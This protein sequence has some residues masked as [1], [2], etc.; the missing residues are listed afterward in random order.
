[1]DRLLEEER[2]QEDAY[3]RVALLKNRIQMLKK[4]R[5]LAK[6]K[7]GKKAADTET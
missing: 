1:M 3:G 4:K 6:A 5:E 2:A 7:G